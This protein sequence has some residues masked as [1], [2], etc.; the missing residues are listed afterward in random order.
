ME[1]LIKFESWAVLW[2]SLMG[3]VLSF[4]S[5]V[6]P[7]IALAICLILGDWRLGV[8]AAKKRKEIINAEGFKKTL[9]KLT[10]YL[11]LILSSEGVKRV[12]FDGFEDSFFPFVAQ[13]PIT[14]IAAFAICMKEFKSISDKAYQ[15]TGVD[16]WNVI[17]ERIETVFSLFKKNKSDDA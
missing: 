2:G 15:L 8:L 11:I 14:Y 1:R 17:S 3:S 13:F 7:F 12:F 4:I 10:V 6:S 9:T 16:F 5:P